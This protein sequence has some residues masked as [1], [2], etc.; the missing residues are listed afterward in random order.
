[1]RASK[2]DLILLDCRLEERDSAGLAGTIA[3]EFGNTA[4]PIVM[5]FSS[6][7]G[8]RAAV[9]QTVGPSVTLLNKPV[10][11]AQLHQVLAETLSGSAPQATVI[12]RIDRS[13]ALRVPLRI[14][15]AEDNP[16]NQKVAVRLLE[17]WGYRPDVV[18]N[19]LEVLAALR[20]QPYDIVLLDVH[21]PEMDGLEAARHIC[22]EWG[23]EKR[24]YLAALTASAM[25][26][27]RDD[28]IAAG[29][30]AYLTK[31]VNLSDLAML[32]ERCYT[33]LAV[34]P[35][36]ADTHLELIV[37]RQPLTFA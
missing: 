11:R 1:M 14:L 33:R 6:A 7:A 28:C 26:K 30:D 19:G 10:R 21:M 20:R 5:L 9:Q 35:N 34:K 36:T 27:D 2:W 37:P 18:G 31:P 8:G 25:K 23:R 3:N 16:V 13:F 17:R 29:M 15:L 32:L 12:S 4:P 24:P 22:A